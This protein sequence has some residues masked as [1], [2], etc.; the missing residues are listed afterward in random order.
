MQRI[1]SKFEMSRETLASEDGS[2]ARKAVLNSV[3]ENLID[4]LQTDQV[5]TE[6]IQGELSEVTKPLFEELH[7]NYLDKMLIS[8]LL[9]AVA[10]SIDK[11][12][13][14]QALIPQIDEFS[15]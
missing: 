11:T 7:I 15:R 8:P 10:N 6:L 5:L 3:S 2:T 14:L 12:M 13:L 4:Y 9:N 1:V